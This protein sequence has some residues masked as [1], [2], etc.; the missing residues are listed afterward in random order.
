[1]LCCHLSSSYQKSLASTVVVVVVVVV[2]SV[3]V[4]VV[5]EV[6]AVAAG[7]AAVDLLRRAEKNVSDNESAWEFKAYCMEGCVHSTLLGSGLEFM[8]EKEILTFNKS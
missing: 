8:T 5:F 1:M 7:I 3:A 4:A 2:G 6:V